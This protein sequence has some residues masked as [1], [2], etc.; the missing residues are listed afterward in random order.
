MSSRLIRKLHRWLGLVF[1]VWAFIGTG[2]QAMRWCA[3]LVLAGIPAY[4]LV[5]HA[6][7]RNG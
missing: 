2:A 6:R 5:R 4:A 1:S 7:K 3:G